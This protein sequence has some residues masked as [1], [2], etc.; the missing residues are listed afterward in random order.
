MKQVFKL[1]LYFPIALA[2]N[3]QFQCRRK[4][5]VVCFK[6]SLKTFQVQ[7]QED[8]AQLSFKTNKTQAKK[9]TTVKHST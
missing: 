2:L 3:F 7:K 6:D 9:T 8:E 1:A 4:T 5:A